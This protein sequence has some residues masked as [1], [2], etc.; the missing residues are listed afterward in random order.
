MAHV[1]FQNV[2]EVNH[3]FPTVSIIEIL[4]S[5]DHEVSFA[6]DSG[7]LNHLPQD[8]NTVEIDLYRPALMSPYQEEFEDLYKILLDSA[9][10]IAERSLELY[11]EIEP[12]CIVVGSLD[13]G[14]AI[15][16][17]SSGIPWLVTGVNPGMLEVPGSLPYTGR[18]LDSLSLK[19]KVAGFFHRRMLRDLNAT[20]N[21]LRES[22]GL[23]ALENAFARQMLQS[24]KYLA[25]TLESL[26]PGEPKYPAKVEFIGSIL[27]KESFENDQSVQKDHW[28]PPVIV[29]LL[30]RISAPDNHVLVQRLIDGLAEK[31][32]T[33]IIESRGEDYGVDEFP[34]NFL[35]VERVDL[36]QLVPDVHLLIHRGN[37]L[38]YAAGIRYGIPSVAIQTGAEGRENA[39]RARLAGIAEVVDVDG[40]RAKHLDDLVTKLIGEPLYRMM[41][42]RL[43]E[44]FRAMH[45]ASRAADLIEG[46]VS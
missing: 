37:Y 36:S 8:L 44:G 4:Q 41:A 16:A 3:I 5:R 1:L 28:Q 12:D 15:A 11:R 17:E 29:A 7:V 14:A 18:G 26:E 19:S 27:W 33:V 43:K 10:S 35:I 38:G 45:P 2:P 9:P 22:L 20:L 25:L 42:E 21:D 24:E 34:E 39:V 46:E 31:E 13:Y 23:A 6:S 40:F 32:C 30:S